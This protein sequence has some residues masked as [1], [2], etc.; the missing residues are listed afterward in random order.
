[1]MRTVPLVIVLAAAATLA[2]CKRT[3]RANET[4]AVTPAMAQPSAAPPLPASI[5]ADSATEGDALTQANDRAIAENKRMAATLGRHQSEDFSKY[6]RLRKGCEAQAHGTLADSTA[7]AV[8]RCID[9]G[10]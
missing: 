7:P 1:M 2:G 8:A 10:W 3:D 9:A 6:E 4:A 5:P